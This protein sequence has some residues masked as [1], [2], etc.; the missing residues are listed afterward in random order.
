MNTLK[1]LF[2]Q[3]TESRL[4]LT[5]SRF[6]ASIFLL[7]LLALPTLAQEVEPTVELG[8]V[9]VKADRIIHKTDGLLLYPSEQQKASSRSGYSLLQQLTLP[10]IRVDEVGHSISAIDQ[11]GS[12]QIRINGII[13]DKAEMLSLDPK[14]IRKIDFID[15]P[16]VRYGDG[17][18]YVIDITT[19]RAD[20]G[21][22]LGTSLTQALTTRDGDYTV[23]GK[24]NTEKSEL[25][26][27]YSFGYRDFKGIRT[28]ETA[29][30]HLNDGSIY[31][32]QRNDLASR[33]RS[34]S[35]Q[36]KLTY[37]LADSSRYVFQASLSGDFS[38]VPGDFSQKQIVDGTQTY[39][40]LEQ[41]QSQSS[42]PVLDLYY[43]Q[44][45][46][47]RQ[48]LTL[49]AVGTYIGT[50][51]SDSYDEGSPYRYD[52]DGRT[53]SL[54]SEAI[55]ENRL[56]PFTL[57]AG[58]NYSQKY[59]NNEYTGDVSSVT[60]MHHNRVYLFSEIKGA[61]GKLRYSAGIG[62]SYLHYRQQAHS[63]DYW[64]FCPKAALSYNFTHSLQLSYNF[65][66]NERTSRVAMISDAAIRTNRM[67]WT[68]G[69]PDLKP[70]R[71]TSHTL[72]LS[73]NDSRLQVNLQG[74]YK[75]CPHP[76]MAVYERTSDDRFIYT[77]RNQ[78]EIDALHAMAYASYW[79][80]PEKLS[81]TAY[82]GLFRC[83]NFGH[84]YTH[85]YTSY[86]A[87]G[88][89]NAYLGNLSLHAYADNG[90]RFLEGETKG[91][92]G[93]DIA[94]KA[95]YSYKDWQFAL[96]WQQ[97]FQHKYKMF[98]SEVL[99]R[100]LQ[101]TTA[102]YSR[103][104]CNLVNLT[105]TWRLTKGRKFRDVNRSILLKDKDTGIIR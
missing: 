23:Y 32:I 70:N 95:A 62:G 35:N 94:L 105:V 4:L 29:H 58:L 98:E 15:N 89:L 5:V 3:E 82:G 56:K 88:A 24:W 39:T 85:C 47:P 46:S 49:N 25:S 80:M 7:L 75:K 55:Y 74:F 52:V 53:Y 36:M 31:T 71:E 28:E 96:I 69:S 61:W 79:L 86:F 33:N 65:Q 40:A 78:K 51:S 13:A 21:Y 41:Q 44:Q 54:L 30:Y 2:Q 66:L 8:E 22:T 64:S 14:S 42:S 19:R 18:A 101:K 102:L 26:L 27:N 20:N 83:F 67:E 17:I 90:S 77:Q 45:F 81:V 37:N 60:P 93:G 68:V 100:N 99:N 50:R 59:T 48:S 63:Y 72:R 104:A 16:G 10:N 91:Y 12:V 6:L 43:F 87:T 11:R 9:E 57:S 76:N 1:L 97:P 103:D 92:S 34:L 73:Y 38:H 84:D